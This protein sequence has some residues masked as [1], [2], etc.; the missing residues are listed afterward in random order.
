MGMLDDA[1]SENM[2][3]HEAVLFATVVLLSHLN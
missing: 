1:R 3:E 2:A